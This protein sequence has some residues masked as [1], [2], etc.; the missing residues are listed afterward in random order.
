MNREQ[1]VTAI[2]DLGAVAVIRAESEEKAFSLIEQCAE[3]GLFN[4]EL[5]FTVPLAHRVIE[6][7]AMRY[8]KEILLGA[9]SVLDSETARIALLSGAEFIVSPHFDGHLVRL[10]NGY[11][12]PSVCGVMTVTEAVSAMEAGCDMLKLFPSEVL[13]L[14]FLK[15]LRGPLPFAKLMPTRRNQCAQ[16]GRMDQSRSRSSWSWR[17]SA[18]GKCL[19]KCAGA[20]CGGTPCEGGTSMIVTFGEMLLRLSPPAHLRLA[21]ASSFDAYYGGAEANTAVCLSCLGE[22]A[23]HVTRLPANAIGRACAGELARYGVDTSCVSFDYGE[24][25][26]LGLYFC[27]NGASQRAS[28]VLY[29]RQNSAFTRLEARGFRLGKHL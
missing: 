10:C 3:G 22:A 17:K 28:Q 6:H 29:D 1:T 8:G 9:G 21:Q 13:G 18:T 25:S 19:P 26:R 27:E 15:A 7:A 20:S 12:K 11:R 4:I 14:P 16:C 24:N 23:R 2:Q 5:T